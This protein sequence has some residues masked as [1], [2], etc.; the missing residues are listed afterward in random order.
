MKE[1]LKALKALKAILT[2]LRLIRQKLEEIKQNL[3][4]KEGNRTGGLELAREI[5]GYSLSTLQKMASTNQ[6]PK[7]SAKR[8][9]IRFE[10]KTLK[11]WMRNRGKGLTEDE[12]D[13]EIAEQYSKFKTRKR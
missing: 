12:L 4:E 9:K 10:E 3:D 5:T 8:E 13:K 11:E 6:I 1:I 7:A 2:E